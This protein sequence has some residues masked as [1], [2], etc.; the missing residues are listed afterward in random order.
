[1]RSRQ[2]NSRK[3]PFNNGFFE[4]IQ[5]YWVVILG[6]ILGIP[7]IMRYLRDAETLG[8][9]N[10]AEEKEKDLVVSNGN[11]ISQL[12]ELNKITSNQF[13]HNLAR[14][15][16]IHLKTDIQTKEAPWYAYLNPFSWSENDEKAYN[17]LKQIANV[18]QRTT[19]V[20]C[21]YVLTR[22][23]LLDD[24]KKMLDSDLIVKLPLFK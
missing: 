24:V 17:Q 21:Y 9:K 7:V 14:N 18:G 2:V 6:L 23:N 12:V 1:M 10:N 11:P 16:A 13:Y 5:K 15:L 22:R 8:N 3:D 20:K 4:L 19:V